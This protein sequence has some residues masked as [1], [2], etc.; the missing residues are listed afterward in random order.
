M[1][2]WILAQCDPYMSASTKAQNAFKAVF[3]EAKQPE[4]INFTKNEILAVS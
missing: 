3:S 1:P 2:Y 4:V